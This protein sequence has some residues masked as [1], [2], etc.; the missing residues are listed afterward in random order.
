MA[1]F[2]RAHGRFCASHPWEVIVTTVTL[3]VCVLSMSVLSEGKVGY[4][5]GINKPCSAKAKE[6]EVGWRFKKKGFL[7]Q[8]RHC[9]SFK[10]ADVLLMIVNCLAVLYIYNQF[11]NLR[12]A[13]SKYLLG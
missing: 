3:T 6:D 10:G 9:L 2:F 12:K 1:R 5:C 11:S 8:T 7:S 4:V 13:G